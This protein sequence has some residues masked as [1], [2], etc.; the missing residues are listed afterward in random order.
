VVNDPNESALL[1]KRAKLA[2]QL[3]GFKHGSGSR[4]PVSRGRKRRRLA[5]YERE[6][7][8]AEGSERPAKRV[9]CGPRGGAY[10]Q[11][12]DNPDRHEQP[13][14]R[15]WQVNSL[16]EPEYPVHS[17]PVNPP[18][19][20][21]LPETLRAPPRTRIPFSVPEAA[22]LPRAVQQDR[23]FQTWNQPAAFWMPAVVGP[24]QYSD[25]FQKL[26]FEQYGSTTQATGGGARGWNAK[27]ERMYE[28]I[29]NS[30]LS[31]GV[32]V[33]ESER[34]AAATVNQQRRNEGRLLYD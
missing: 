19:W 8:E 33:R 26:R 25:R 11:P 15:S 17:A 20:A 7:M 13:G 10:R 12:Y 31:R 16:P 30:Y 21:E 24:D 4:K 28:A 34:I 23:D 22:Y 14:E 27:D 3:R 29:R 2:L 9:C 32:N 6:V 1:R 5:E 18:A